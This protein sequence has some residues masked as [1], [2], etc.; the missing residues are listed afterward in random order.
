MINDQIEIEI[1]L[2]K[3]VRRQYRLSFCFCHVLHSTLIRHIV[4]FFCRHQIEVF[5]EPTP[6]SI[7]FKLKHF[8]FLDAIHRTTHILVVATDKFVCVCVCAAC[9][10]IGDRGTGYV[11]VHM[12]CQNKCAQ[13]RMPIHLSLSVMT[14]SSYYVTFF[15][16]W[17]RLFFFRSMCVIFIY[18]L[19]F[20]RQNI[21]ISNRHFSFHLFKDA[22]CFLSFVVLSFA[23]EVWSSHHRCSLRECGTTATHSRKYGS[24]Q[25][26]NEKKKKN[27]R[28]N[29]S[30]HGIERNR[31]FEIIA[32]LGIQK[33]LKKNNETKETC[34]CVCAFLLV[35]RWPTSLTKYKHFQYTLDQIANW[36]V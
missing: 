20:C 32:I 14:P 34:L 18:R 25:K 5:M 12:P 29:M 10:S 9:L 15:F 28:N 36:N 23:F 2:S 17:F 35:C 8:F 31:F 3:F 27:H 7:S 13:L 11:L 21:Y 4:F 24:S 33:K 22:F 19:S 26:Y 30:W 1:R 16:F 6:C